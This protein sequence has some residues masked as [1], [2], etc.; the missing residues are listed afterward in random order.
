MIEQQLAVDS[1]VPGFLLHG[2][3]RIL[4]IAGIGGMGA[5]YKALDMQLGGRVVAVKELSKHGLSPREIADTTEAFTAEA[6][7]LASLHHASLPSIHEYFTA[8][9]RW[10]LVMDFIEGETLEHQLHR[11]GS[12]GLPVADVLRIAYQLCTVLAFLH[13]HEPPIIFR[14][15]KP[16]NVMLT[17]TRHLY[18][19]DFGI[20]R[21][22][23]L[24]KA[25][26]TVSLGTPGYAAPE[27]YGSAQTTVRS[28]IFSLGVT[29]H[30][31]L[32]G[33]DP[34]IT[35]FSFA[36][37]RSW[38]PR[39][40]R[41]LET[42]I[43]RMVEVDEGRRPPTVAALRQDLEA[44]ARSA[45]AA[46]VAT[47]PPLPLGRA[48]RASLSSRAR[49]PQL[50]AHPSVRA[51]GRPG[52]VGVAALGFLGAVVG[53]VCIAA[54]LVSGV[55]VD[56][57]GGGPSAA[58]ADAQS[59]L[60]SSLPPLYGDIAILAQDTYFTPD[61]AAYAHDWATMQV[62]YHTE[63][64]DAQLGCGQAGIN[65]STVVADADVV[66]S[67]LVAIQGDNRGLTTTAAIVNRDLQQVQRDMTTV[68]GALQDLEQAAAADSNPDTLVASDESDANEALAIA[69]QQVSASNHALHSA[70]SQ[71]AQYDKEAQQLD[72]D[73]QR[74]AASMTC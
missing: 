51:R 17:P 13:H 59:T 23:T 64:H 70:H 36:S 26:D 10:Y 28:D 54:V 49:R 39:T 60:A 58:I 30:Q 8:A 56:L 55:R 57:T 33:R 42:L 41:A 35:P 16:S 61:L 3:Y 21:L 2:R 27:Q 32:T 15:L 67:D 5:V 38:N 34:S 18:L 71:G 53:V 52:C 37:I 4:S 25:H 72:Q 50:L 22:F 62:D 73:A 19:I 12:P 46:R 24:G 74:L 20:A 6:L 66:A 63:Q 1:L 45:R 11:A 68:V 44:L 47:P 31:L 7:L 9:Q 43:M 29:L 48:Q 14:D 40:P 69:Q 65:A